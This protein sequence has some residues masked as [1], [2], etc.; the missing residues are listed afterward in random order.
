MKVHI[1]LAV[2][3]LFAS[4]CSSNDASPVN[5]RTPPNTE[6][7]P[8][9]TIA[10]ELPLLRGENR[11]G[12][13]EGFNPDN[14]EATTTAM[15][16]R[17]QEALD[18][19]MSV[20]R[21]QIDWP[22]L[23]PSKSSFDKTALESRLEEMKDQGLQTFLLISAYDAGEAV[24]PGDLE[25]KDFDDP[26]FI[27]R[28]KNLMDWVIPLL[29]EYDGYLISVSNEAEDSFGEGSN[30][31]NEILAFLLEIKN[32]I[33]HIDERMAVTVTVSE[34]SLDTGKPGINE[35]LA[36][37][38]VAAFNF[39]GGDFEDDGSPYYSANSE[40]QIKSDIQ[41]M[42][43]ASG[44]KNIV[45][46][47]LGM[48]SGYTDDYPPDSYPTESYLNSSEETQRKFFEVFFREMQNHDRIKAAYIFQM[49]DWSPDTTQIFSDLLEDEG[50]DP[51]FINQFAETLNTMGLV[52]Y[53]DGTKKP[54]WDEFA[55]W[56]GVFDSM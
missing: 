31:H 47:E 35:I 12:I 21:L 18:A 15:A 17:W 22:E 51:A 52:R 55:D 50:L 10:G 7:P 37:G 16:A 2:V 46:Q 29:V 1:A 49:V 27:Q 13:I 28:F 43:D 6:N 44:D 34:G 36:A 30:L 38:D 45:I 33:R 20:A 26:E 25:G 11:I 24:V 48:W 39:Y 41:R 9:E 3:A 54:A 53:P 42:L 32:H 4:G 23:E 56:V 14:P 40:V 8:N 5:D 19:G